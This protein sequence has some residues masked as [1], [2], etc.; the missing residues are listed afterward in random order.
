MSGPKIDHAEIERQRKAELERQRQERLRRIKEETDKLNKEISK[1]EK[2][3]DHIA[4]CLVSELSQIDTPSELDLVLNEFNKLQKESINSLEKALNFNVP[5][6]PDDIVRCSNRLANSCNNITENFSKEVERLKKPIQ[7][8]LKHQQTHN[9]IKSIEFSGKVDK[10]RSIDDFDFVTKVIT[11]ESAEKI[12]VKVKEKATGVLK[13]IEEF[14]NSDSI[15][16][17]DIKILSMIAEKLY[18][19]VFESEKGLNASESEYKTIRPGIIKNLQ[20]FDQLYHDYYAEYIVFLHAVNKYKKS[21]ISVQPKPKHQFVSIEQLQA[22]IDLLTQQSRQE[23]EKNFIREQIDE[24]MKLHGYNVSKEIVFG[25]NSKGNHLI[26][27]KLSDQSA[28]HIHLSDDKQIMMEVVA[29]QN[30][31]GNDSDM[32]YGEIQSAKDI[33]D[34]EADFLESEMGNFC[35]LHP[36]IIDELKI[37]GVVF[38]KQARKDVNKK[39]CRK[40]LIKDSASPITVSQDTLINKDTRRKSKKKLLAQAL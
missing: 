17:S 7:E 39:Y 23:N 25:E 40:I 38:T 26:C 22:E 18:K 2:Q 16:V 8:Y 20:I 28:I 19:T 33:N 10:V 6:E 31:A 5:S 35:D 37:R 24:V 15:Q 32:N 14:I 11:I 27:N 1:V 3:F 13:E 29:V 21:K 36:K 9:K 34:A 30:D 12:E 4:N